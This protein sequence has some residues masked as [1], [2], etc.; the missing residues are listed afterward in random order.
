MSVLDQLP[1]L[2]TAHILF[3]DIVGFA[4]LRTD[5]QVAAQ[6][7]LSRLVQSAP[8]IASLRKDTED[9]LL[10]STGDGIVL[11]FFKDLLSPVRCALQIAEALTQA[12]PGFALR[13]GVHTGPVSM[14]DDINGNPDAAGDG[15]VQAQRV[16]DLGDAGHI[17]LSGD[18]ARVLLKI[19]PWPQYLR[20]LGTVRVKHKQEL[21]VYSLYGR[22]NGPFCGNNTVP[23]KVQTDNRMRQQERRLPL[24]VR[25]APYRRATILMSLLTV[26]AAT[27]WAVWER[28]PVQVR[29]AAA[30]ITAHLQAVQKPGKA[31]KKPT[32]SVA[33]K[34]HAPKSPVRVASTQTE[35]TS[36]TSPIARIPSL[37]R[38]S[39]E[40]AT[41]LA[42][43]K[44]FVVVEK[45]PRVVKPGFEEGTVFYQ[46]V[47]A[48][49]RTHSGARIAVRVAAWP[50]EKVTSE[51]SS[52]EATTDPS[53]DSLETI[54]EE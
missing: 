16:M 26:T 13:M 49:K 22:L 35:A 11:L 27:A 2:R 14:L 9:F 43:S 50:V 46:S 42:E 31:A 15:I 45:G 40:E 30:T 24:S 18:A 8:E 23:S 20:D 37:R 4:K 33:V 21:H 41:A 47:P 53:S 10:R 51:E 29:A 28:N 39:L 32:K 1:T 44:G 12:R 7:E 34:P 3:L 19:A 54:K 36:P 6:K 52:Q 5:Q 17:L 25:L 48:G 38:L